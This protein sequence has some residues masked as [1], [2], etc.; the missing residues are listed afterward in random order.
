VINRFFEAS[1]KDPVIKKAVTNIVESIPTDTSQE[2]NTNA[3]SVIKGYDIMEFIDDLNDL[4]TK[5]QEKTQELKEF[6]FQPTFSYS[7]LTTDESN[8]IRYEIISRNPGVFH[9]TN[10]P[11]SSGPRAHKWLLTDIVEDLAHPGYKVLVYIQPMDNVISIESWSKNYRDANKAAFV[12]EDL[13]ETFSYVFKQKGLQILRFQGREKDKYREVSNIQTY[14]IPLTYYLRTIKTKL[15]HEK[16]LEDLT[17][18]LKI[19]K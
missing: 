5:Y 14:G 10:N 13:L 16:I 1:S 11:N 4:L 7:K 6:S 3:G 18:S 8:A 12:L 2:I 15:V 19:N 9:Q 17:I